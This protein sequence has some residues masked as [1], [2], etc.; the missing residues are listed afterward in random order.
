MNEQTNN[1]ISLEAEV[2]ED[3]KQQLDSIGKWLVYSAVIGFASLGLTIIST[4]VN[5][6][7]ESQYDVA[8]NLFQTIII[9]AF[10]LLVNI[11]LYT[12]GNYIKKGILTADQGFF[13]TGL[14]KLNNYFKILGILLIIVICI[15]LLAFVFGGILSF[16]K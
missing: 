12:A 9:I 10:S 4:L 15:F 8:A 1:L 6:N 5:N 16:L 13:N 14:R 3:A 7:R 11:T 2:T